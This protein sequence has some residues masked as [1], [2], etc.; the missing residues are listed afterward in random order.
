MTRA[1][2]LFALPAAILH[3]GP[4]GRR[5]R[6]AAPNASTPADFKLTVN[7]YGVRKS[8]IARAELVFRS[9]VAY[10][11]VSDDVEEVTVIDPARQRLQL[12]DLAQGSRPRSRRAARRRASRRIHRKV[13]R[14][15]RRPGES[16]GQ[17]QSR[18][19]L[20]EP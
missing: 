19:G 11:F 4:R 18:L 8:P 7:L 10:Q 16:R 1:W 12:L 6:P 17:G 3:D 15:G 13:S 9:G 5:R 14:L 20:D 2:R